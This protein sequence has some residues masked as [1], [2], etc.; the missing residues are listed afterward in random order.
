MALGLNWYLNRNVR[1]MI[2]DNIVTVRKGTA[3]EPQS[4]RAR[5]STSSASACSSPTKHSRL[6]RRLDR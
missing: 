1:M 2:D 6:K 4:R 5:T 3:G